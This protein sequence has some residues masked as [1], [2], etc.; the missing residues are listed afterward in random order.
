MTSCKY[1]WNTHPLLYNDVMLNHM[2][3]WYHVITCEM[4]QSHPITWQRWLTPRS[5]VKT[6]KQVD[7]MI[8]H[9][10]Y[11]KTRWLPLKTKITY[12]Y[13]QIHSAYFKELFLEPSHYNV[14]LIQLITVSL[15]VF[16]ILHS[17]LLKRR[18]YH[19]YM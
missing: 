19:I 5:H 14:M 15:F 17:P 13:V 1:T 2:K 7:L 18:W 3:Y 10:L 4:H 11:T 6:W 16:N 12:A 9:G 8:K